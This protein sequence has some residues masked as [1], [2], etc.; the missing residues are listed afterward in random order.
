MAALGRAG[1]GLGEAEAIW[2]ELVQVLDGSSTL[3]VFQIDGEGE[4]EKT[5]E[6]IGTNSWADEFSDELQK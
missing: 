5:L 4:T 2:E 3:T 6:D 1:R